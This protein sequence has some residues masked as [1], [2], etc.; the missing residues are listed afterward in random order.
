MGT[1][2]ARG[3]PH[4]HDGQLGS[5]AGY[6][7]LHPWHHPHENRRSHSRNDG[8]RAAT[9]ESHVAVGHTAGLNMVDKDKNEYRTIQT[10]ISENLVTRMKS[11]EQSFQNLS[12]PR[13]THYTR[14]PLYTQDGKRPQTLAIGG[15]EEMRRDEL[16][17]QVYK[18]IKQLQ[19]DVGLDGIFVPGVR[20]GYAMIPRRGETE[21][22]QRT[23]AIKTE[24]RFKDANL[25]RAQARGRAPQL[26]ANNITAVAEEEA[27]QASRESSKIVH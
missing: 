1:F 23:R 8:H 20:R 24:Q 12:R 11:L 15:R 17:E 5:R 9:Y 22:H 21:E 19:L 18:A 6:A 16:L 27:S 3:K 4:I 26:L 14:N 7:C 25:S 10:E 2:S 13:S